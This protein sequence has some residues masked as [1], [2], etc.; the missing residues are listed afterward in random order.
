MN[1]R[2]L[3]ACMPKSGSTFLQTLLSSL[4]GIN[5]VALV[6]EYDRREQ[7]ICSYIVQNLCDRN[8]DFIAQHHVR[9]SSATER[10]IKQYNLNTVVLVRNIYDVIFSIVDHWSTGEIICPMAYVPDELVVWNKEKK[11][12][13]IMQMVI[14]WYINFYVSWMKSNIPNGLLLTYEDLNASPYQVVKHICEQ[15]EMSF[16]ETEVLKAIAETAE[17]NT[18]KNIGVSGRGLETPDHLKNNI[19]KLAGYYSDVDFTHIGIF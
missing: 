14:P 15:F 16:E 13:F 11:F 18:R 8:I 7:E 19:K 3:L 17:K 1:N 2:I 12:E 5:N 6:P 9:C 10:I 4:P